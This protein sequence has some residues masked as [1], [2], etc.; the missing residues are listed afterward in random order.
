MDR[1]IDGL[2]MVEATRARHQ[3]FWERSDTARPLLSIE[4]SFTLKPLEI[5]VYPGI[6]LAPDGYLR[7][8]MLDP[9]SHFNQLIAGWED[10]GPVDGDLF[11][12]MTPYLLVPWLEAI[13][14]CPVRYFRDAGT[15]YPEAPGGGWEH[16]LR[17]Q[18]GRLDDPWRARL[19]MFLIVLRSL[20][21]GRYPVGISMPMRGPLDML[22]ALVGVPEMCLAFAERPALVREALDRLTDIWIDVVGEQLTLLPPFA[23]GMA[24]CEQYGLWAPGPNAVTQCDLAVVIS[25]RA[26]ERLLVPCDERICAS[27]A[28][29]IMHLH[30][31]GL[32][33]LEPVLAVRGLAAVQIVVDPGTADPP[34]L[35]LLPIFQRV[36]RAGKPLIIHCSTITQAEVDALLGALSP[37]GLCIGGRLA[38]AAATPAMDV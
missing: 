6:E 20:A 31:A 29:P 4:P 9:Q 7:P 25:P 38:E 36:Q 18:P 2:S 17:L 32:H 8:D 33:V 23:G 16:V 14:G 3:A 5:P 19:R 11:R 1:I 10:A 30:S 37:R 12:I 15:M 34:L 28:Y 22:A 26:Y 24:G 35:S 27:L 21:A 13:C